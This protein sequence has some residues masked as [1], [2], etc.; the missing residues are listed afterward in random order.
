ME[1]KSEGVKKKVFCFVFQRS[2]PSSKHSDGSL[3]TLC[4]ITCVLSGNGRQ[5]LKAEPVVGGCIQKHILKTKTRMQNVRAERI[6]RPRREGLICL[7]VFPNEV[8][9]QE[10]RQS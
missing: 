8:F 4:A 5:L 7:F 9:L 10:N 1:A 6:T 2:F 3:G